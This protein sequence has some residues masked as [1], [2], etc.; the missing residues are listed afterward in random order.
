MRSPARP[1]HTGLP[2]GS[3]RHRPTHEGWLWA[4]AGAWTGSEGTQCTPDGHS[5][6]TRTAPVPLAA[7]LQKPDVSCQSVGRWGE[8]LTANVPTAPV[9]TRTPG[10]ALS[11]C[12]CRGP[13]PPRRVC[14][15][16][17]G[18]YRRGPRLSSSW[19]RKPIP[20]PLTSCPAPDSGHRALRQGRSG[21][22]DCS[23][24]ATAPRHW[25]HAVLGK[26]GQGRPAACSLSL[27]AVGTERPRAAE[28]PPPVT[29]P[30]GTSGSDGP[31]EPA[32]GVRQR[33]LAPPRRSVVFI[34]SLRCTQRVFPSQMR[35]TELFPHG[36]C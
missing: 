11:T 31:Q 5:R 1:R 4:A 12:R 13:C 35:R 24:T 30:R 28:T 3:G 26:C 20:L 7:P 27:P 25:A 10:T 32:E 9:K 29:G 6:P 22:G 17:E 14:V 16:Q 21:K 15:Q 19:A 36:R 23:N 34:I 2:A 18:P 8:M 33:C